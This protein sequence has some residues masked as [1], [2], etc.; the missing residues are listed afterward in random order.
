MTQLPSE[1]FFSWIYTN[2]V[3]QSDKNGEIHVQRFF[4]TWSITVGGTEETGPYLKAMWNRVFSVLSKE[5]NQ[6]EVRTVL[7]LGL[8]AGGEI[9]TIHRT[10]PNAHVTVIEH[11]PVMVEIAKKASLYAPHPFPTVIVG[12]AST[13][14]SNLSAHYDL[15]ILD[16]FNGSK[17]DDGIFTES[18]LAHLT[19]L[20]APGGALAVNTYRES[21]LL[22]K[23]SEHFKKVHSFKHIA[24]SLGIFVSK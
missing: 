4:G 13:S 3:F 5:L 1:S 10:F 19:K 21:H 16:L 11:D 22:E 14:I 7:M 2:K 23:V 9:E 17:A 24:N 12:D 8:G 20:L 6:S 18:S 15:I